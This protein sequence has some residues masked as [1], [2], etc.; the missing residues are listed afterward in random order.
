MPWNDATL[1]GYDRIKHVS[2]FDEDERPGFRTKTARLAAA[3][4]LWHEKLQPEKPEP[5]P[6]HDGE[7]YVAPIHHRKSGVLLLSGGTTRIVDGAARW[8]FAHGNMIDSEINF[9]KS[10]YISQLRELQ[11]VFSKTPSIF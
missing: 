10:A 7:R 1:L 9:V 4:S 11:C 3:L 5:L 2:E 8:N 6:Y